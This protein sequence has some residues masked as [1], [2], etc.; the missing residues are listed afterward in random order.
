MVPLVDE[1]NK[2][3]CNCITDVVIVQYHWHLKLGFY[4]QDQ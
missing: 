4:E 1:S 2:S 3:E